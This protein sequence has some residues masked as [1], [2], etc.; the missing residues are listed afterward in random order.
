MLRFV[1]PIHSLLRVER[2]DPVIPRRRRF[3]R[4][5]KGQKRLS[6]SVETSSGFGFLPSRDVIAGNADR[7]LTALA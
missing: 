7:P 6:T 5:K 4:V 1:F 3:T 2:V